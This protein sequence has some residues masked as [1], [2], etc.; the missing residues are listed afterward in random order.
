MAK[1]ISKYSE[2]TSR[3][4]K[5]IYF[6]KMIDPFDEDYPTEIGCFSSKENVEKAKYLLEKL[7]E[8]QNAS[9]PQFRVEEYDLDKSG[10]VDIDKIEKWPVKKR[11]I[12]EN[13]PYGEEEWE[14]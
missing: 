9:H 13:D 2:F 7:A 4:P 10:Y 14:E 1:P 8:E 6:L 5:K 12:S 3:K 11:K